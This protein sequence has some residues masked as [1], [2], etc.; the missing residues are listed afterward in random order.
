MTVHPFDPVYNADCTALVL[1][2]MPSPVSRE[3]GFYYA[4]PQNR[5]WAVL[6]ALFNEPFPVSTEERRRLVLKYHIALW[7]VLASCDIEGASDSK[8][9]NPVCNDFSH[10]LQSAKI[11]RVYTTGRKAYEL[12]T[13]L[14]YPVTRLAA[15][16]LPSTSAANCRVTFPRLL[17]S[18]AVLKRNV[19]P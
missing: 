19:I 13:K 10:L 5:F 11:S 1:G 4:H 8:I 3:K 6:S 9:K 18:Y 7:D 15:I 17:E 16:P 12:Y 2:T 14:C